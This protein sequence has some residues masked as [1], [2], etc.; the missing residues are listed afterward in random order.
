MQLKDLLKSPEMLDMFR[1]RSPAH[2]DLCAEL[3]IDPEGVPLLHIPYQSRF[4]RSELQPSLH[5][6]V[7][8]TAMDSAMG[9]A[10]ML[11]MEELS[12]L[13]TLELRYD[14]L[15]PPEKEGGISIQSQCDS[16][17][18]G[19]AYL[20]SAASDSTGVFAKA[21]ARFILTPGSSSFLETAMAAM[22]GEQT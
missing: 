7:V 8:M 3:T 11:E 20:T 2:G 17:D 13:A 19:I 14:E 6:G 9:L 15:R 22:N 4:A 5:A 1:T 21:V 12:S 18:D 16:I 10:T